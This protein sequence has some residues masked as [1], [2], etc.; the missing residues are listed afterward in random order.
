MALKRAA[1]RATC[2]GPS[3]NSKF[4]KNMRASVTDGAVPLKPEVPQAFC[5]RFDLYLQI[6]LCLNG[7]VISLK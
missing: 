2:V 6:H 4:E 7:I 5:E 3:V 1:P